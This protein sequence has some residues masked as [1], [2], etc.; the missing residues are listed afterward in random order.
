M[1][2]RSGT[3]YCT[4]QASH[5][6]SQA[7]LPSKLQT[8]YPILRQIYEERKD[9]SMLKRFKASSTFQATQR[10][11]SSSCFNRG[12]NRP[13]K[14]TLT[15]PNVF[16]PSRFDFS[17]SHVFSSHSRVGSPTMYAG[18]N[19]CVTFITRDSVRALYVCATKPD[20]F[21]DYSMIY[22]SLRLRHMRRGCRTLAECSACY[23]GAVA[24]DPSVVP[25]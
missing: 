1:P 11:H 8:P 17:R 16:W 15:P 25:T 23:R 22:P 6:R 14:R 4:H 18:P 20:S 5:S 21:P 10:C 7:P 12:V 9:T 2:R 13:T 19:G 24:V 3:G